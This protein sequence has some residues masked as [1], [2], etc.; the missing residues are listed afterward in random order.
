MKL[1]FINIAVWL[2][3]HLSFSFGLLVVKDSFFQENHWA[4]FLFQ[5]RTFE[6]KGILWRE[7]F[8][9]NVWKDKLP[10]GAS[11]FNVGYKKKQLPDKRSLTITQF[12]K[13]TKRA[14]LTHWLLLIPAPLFFFWNPLWAGLL[15]LLYAVIANIPFI[16][17][18]R[19]NRI[20][21]Y[22]VL[23][24]TKRVDNEIG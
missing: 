24:R 10:D 11:L 18:Q 21:L 17:I 12:I 23:K 4:N 3:I 9:V 22:K 5:E 19:Y 13:E 15:I 7:T 2:F 14:E 8:R 16:I 1:L 6:R 20:R